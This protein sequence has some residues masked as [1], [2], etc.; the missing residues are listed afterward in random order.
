M[1]R[2]H[3]ELGFHEVTQSK[4]VVADALHRMPRN[5]WW[6]PYDDGLEKGLTGTLDFLAAKGLSRKIRGAYH[7]LRIFAGGFRTPRD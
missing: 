1:G 3:G 5:F 7:L 4:T 2:C 6:L